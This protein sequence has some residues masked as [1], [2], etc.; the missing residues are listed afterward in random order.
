MQVSSRLGVR[1]VI[2]MG[3]ALAIM[4]MLLSASLS[5]DKL[6]GGRQKYVDEFTKPN[7]HHSEIIYAKK[8]FSTPTSKI[9]K[10]SYGEIVLLHMLGDAHGHP[11]RGPLR[12]AAENQMVELIARYLEKKNN[13]DS[14]ALDDL[15][16][17]VIARRFQIWIDTTHPD[18]DRKLE[19]LEPEEKAR[20]EAADS[21]DL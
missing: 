21:G 17:D 20:A 9:S 10:A 13:K 15:Y 18:V 8:Y 12:E 19:P 7:S 5:K 4:L 6:F 11:L 16:F 3:F 1:G 2:R 14:Y